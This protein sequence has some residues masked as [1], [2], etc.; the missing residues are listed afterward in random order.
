MRSFSQRMGTK[1]VKGVMQTVTKT[2]PIVIN[3]TISGSRT[4]ATVSC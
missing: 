4:N 2:V 1:P 3:G